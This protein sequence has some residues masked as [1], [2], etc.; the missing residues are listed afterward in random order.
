M[1]FRG[2]ALPLL[3]SLLLHGLLLLVMWFCPTQS[4]SPALSIESTSIAV[5]ACSLDP[6]PAANPREHDLHPDLRG[7]NVSTDFT[8]QLRDAPPVSPETLTAAGPT[9][10]FRDPPGPAAAS[11]A[12]PAEG[13]PS[14]DGNGVAGSLFPLP[15]TA[16]SVVY[17]LDRSVSMGVNNKLDTA[18][19]ELL[20]SLR[21]LPPT[22]RF[23]V[24]T[25]NTSAEPLV[26][27]GRIDLLPAEPAIITQAA[28]SLQTLTATGK[29]DH[30]NALRR[31][32]LLHPEV[33]YFVTD[34]DDLKFEE[35]ELITHSNQGTAIHAIE[36]TRRP[37]PL[38]D[39]PLAELARH[40]RGTYRRVWVGD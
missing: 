37:T 24:I 3:L 26:I 12:H 27:D 28:Q 14:G 22:A 19:Q 32:L 38:P 21:R 20:T 7:P 36:L 10:S 35:V 9:L 39:S 4:P 29:T 6:G 31:G 33:L 8:P 40:N 2:L 17:V 1:T 18:C 23:Q 25:Y 5:E 15:A 30:A 16:S 11:E 34:A 13:G